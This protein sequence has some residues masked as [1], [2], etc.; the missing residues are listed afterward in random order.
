MLNKKQNY[1]KNEGITTRK[2]PTH[3]YLV[4][5]IKFTERG[6]VTERYAGITNNP[7]RRI[8][9]HQEGRGAKFL[10][11]KVLHRVAILEP[12]FDK[13][14][15]SLDSTDCV[16]IKQLNIWELERQLKRLKPW[17]KEEIIHAAFGE[18][19][20]RTLSGVPPYFW[21]ELWKPFW[22]QCSNQCQRV[23]AKIGRHKVIT[24]VVSIGRGGGLD[25]SECGSTGGVFQ[26]LNCKVHGRSRSLSGDCERCLHEAYMESE[27]C[28]GANGLC[29]GCV[30]AEHDRSDVEKTWCTAWNERGF[31]V[32]P[33][34]KKCVKFKK[35][36]EP[37]YDPNFYMD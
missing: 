22:K 28:K 37:P 5:C 2:K 23:Y 35:Y 34:V 32:R 13:I 14:W 26:E 30:H 21:P 19:E 4:E 16:T 33:R 11:G 1:I 6:A 20:K 31:P 10:K 24:G 36:V 15:G 7:L 18:C 29:G 12:R 8:S 9:E 17:V 25:C 3:L 27:S